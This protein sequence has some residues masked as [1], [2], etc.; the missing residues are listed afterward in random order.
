MMEE[1]RRELA[2]NRML[3]SMELRKEADKWDEEVWKLITCDELRNP[4]RVVELSLD[5]ITGKIE[6]ASYVGHKIIQGDVEICL[7]TDNHPPEDQVFSAVLK[8]WKKK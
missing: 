6:E 2:V 1:Y 8:E 4:D 7:H 3:K 5:K